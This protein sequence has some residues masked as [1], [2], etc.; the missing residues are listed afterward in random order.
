MPSVVIIQV[1]IT[2]K[3][4]CWLFWKLAPN[5]LSI[6]VACNNY[7]SPSVSTTFVGP[8][9]TGGLGARTGGYSTIP[10]TGNTGTV[11]GLRESSAQTDDLRRKLKMLS[12]RNSRTKLAN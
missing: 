11:F 9:R 8:V 1:T 4:A 3:V 5:F 6:T 2:N 7:F 10:G 12:Y